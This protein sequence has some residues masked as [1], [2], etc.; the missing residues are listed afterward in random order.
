MA[1]KTGGISGNNEP[2]CRISL[3]T[4]T[5]AFCTGTAVQVESYLI[6]DVSGKC[7]PTQNMCL[8]QG[9]AK[10]SLF[11]RNRSITEPA[12]SEAHS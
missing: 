6:L 4:S 9:R 7:F 2:V 8:V 1:R 11:L 3:I 12:A 10:G 5:H